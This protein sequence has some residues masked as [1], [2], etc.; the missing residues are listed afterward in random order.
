MEAASA[1]DMSVNFCQTKRRATAQ[2]TA[3]FI[4]AAMRTC[5]L[6]FYKTHIEF[7]RIILLPHWTKKLH[8]L[9]FSSSIPYLMKTYEII[10]GRGYAIPER[11]RNTG[12]VSMCPTHG[13]TKMPG[14]PL[15]WT[16]IW[17][18][19]AM[20]Q[21]VHLFCGTRTHH[22]QKDGQSNAH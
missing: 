19:Y 15:H 18:S 12:F 2:K 1:S 3:I 14:K 20:C 10:L 13:Y 5:N 9:H 21:A 7:N 8:L 17:W 11:P 4:L 22:K 16:K 6:A